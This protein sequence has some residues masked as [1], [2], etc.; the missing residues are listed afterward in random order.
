MEQIA[1]T[2]EDLLSKLNDPNLE[3]V[4]IWK[5]D[6]HTN[7]EIAIRLNRTRRTVQRMLD[8]IRVIWLEECD[9][10]DEHN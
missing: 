5:L 6:G 9:G 4:V 2:Y 1:S 3:K 7:D 8:L 10:P